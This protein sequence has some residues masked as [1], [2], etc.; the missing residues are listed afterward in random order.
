LKPQYRLLALDMDGTLLNE[1]FAID[2]QTAQKLAALSAGGVRLVLCSGRRFCAAVGY[3]KEL[4]LSG[5]IVVNN[6]TIVKEVATGRT[7][8]AEYFPREQLPALLHLL[9]DIGLPAV[10][11]TDDYPDCDF[12][13]EPAEDSNEYHA[14]FVNRNRDMARVVRNLAEARCE[15]LVQVNVF[16]TY[17]TLLAA[18]ERIREAMDGKV[19]TAII[20]H[21]KYRASSL[22]IVS[23]TASKWKALQWIAEQWR[24]KPEE[25]VAIGDEVND[26]EMIRG[27]GYGVA[28]S[29]ALDEVKAVADYV[30]REPQNLGVEE[31]IDALLQCA[32]PARAG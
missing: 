11:L 21:L 24:I 4:G 3:A 9:D 32:G 6:G 16:H 27:A 22:D 1:E 30:T 18:E 2:P 10:L 19:G 5:P 29:N 17:P 15:R 26:I 7:L 8:Y 12:C 25:I 23:P 31:V 13:V 20:R 14:E 28:V